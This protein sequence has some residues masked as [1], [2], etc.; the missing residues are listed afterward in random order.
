MQTRP[1]TTSAKVCATLAALFAVGFG[2]TA[3]GCETAPERIPPPEHDCAGRD[4]TIW[5]AWALPIDLSIEEVHRVERILDS[6]AYC[7]QAQGRAQ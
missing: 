5:L 1:K 7:L 6:L 4:D 2:V 3:V